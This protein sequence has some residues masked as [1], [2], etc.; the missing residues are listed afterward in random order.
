ME[1]LYLLGALNSKVPHY[2]MHTIASTEWGGYY[3]YKPM[4]LVQLPIPARDVSNKSNKDR[5]DHIALLADRMLTL[6][7]QKAN[8]TTDHERTLLE[9]QINATD[10]QI[11]QLVY[12]LYGLT[13]EEISIH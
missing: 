12:A 2:L 9:R 4:Y 5:H 3:E 7:Q 13:E 6:N 11:D 1:D 8:A 10:R